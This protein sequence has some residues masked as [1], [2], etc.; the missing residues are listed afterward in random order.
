MPIKLVTACGYIHMGHL[1]KWIDIRFAVLCSMKVI[2]TGML[3]CLLC[4]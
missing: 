3:S 2:R 1:P 4:G